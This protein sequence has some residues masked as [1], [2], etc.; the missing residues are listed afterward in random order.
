[1]IAP[2]RPAVMLSRGISLFAG[3]ALVMAIAA[4]ALT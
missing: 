2:R 4:W 3:F 1:V